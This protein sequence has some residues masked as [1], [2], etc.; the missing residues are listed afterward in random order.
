MNNLLRIVRSPYH[1]IVRSSLF[2]DAVIKNSDST[3]RDHLA[4]ERTF[5]AW[6]RTGLAYLGAGTGLFYSAYHIDEKHARRILPA[7]GCFTLNGA[8]IL[9]FSFLRYFDNLEHIERG[10]FA[11]SK[12]SFIFVFA[13]TSFLTTAAVAILYEEAGLKHYSPL[14]PTSSS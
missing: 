3:A 10:V 1:R 11:P 7:C 4:N 13:S 14:L 8:G 5:L 2:S 9:V 12:R 6:A